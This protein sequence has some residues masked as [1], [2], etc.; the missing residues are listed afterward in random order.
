MSVN[1]KSKNQMIYIRIRAELISKFLL[2][3]AEPGIFIKRFKEFCLKSNLSVKTENC[4]NI[5][6][7]ERICMCIY[8]PFTVKCSH[9][10]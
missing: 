2:K 6:E 5:L 8:V 10:T 3:S 1:E 4:A 7:F 9:S